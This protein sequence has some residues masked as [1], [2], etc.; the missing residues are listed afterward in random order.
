MHFGQIGNGKFGKDD[1]FCCNETNFSRYSQSFGWN[2]K[3]IVNGDKFWCEIVCKYCGVSW[4]LVLEKSLGVSS[5]DVN[6]S[7]GT[8]TRFWHLAHT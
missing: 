1:A 7:L 2:D 4:L 6:D 5:D 3:S 8:K